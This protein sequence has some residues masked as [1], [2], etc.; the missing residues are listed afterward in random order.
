MNPGLYDVTTRLVFGINRLKTFKNI[1][2]KKL[3]L[4]MLLATALGAK[5]QDPHFSQFFEAPLY[6]NPS[7]AGL[8]KG[9]V[10]A[11]GVYRSQ[12]SSVTTPY[13][14][15]S[16][17]F[18]YKHP[19]GESNDF[20]T[21]GV[22]ML[23]DRAGSTALTT[24]NFLPALNYHK[25]LSG[26]KSKYLSLGFMA[27]YVGRSIDRSKMIT[28]NSYTTGYAG[29]TF[30]NAN[31]HYLDGSV[32]MS[33]NS[34][35]GDNSDNSYF[36]GLALHHL[37]QAKN[38][39]YTNAGF[40]VQPKW[41]ASAGV[42]LAANDYSY[43]TIQADFSKQGNYTEI[44]G[45]LLYSYKLGPDPDAPDYVLHFGGFV[46]VKDSFIPVVKVDYN[47]FS[48]AISYDVTTSQLI[49]A[50]Q[51]RGGAELSVTYAAFSN[52]N[53]S[54]RNAVLCPRF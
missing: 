27:G 5:A 51:A 14:N 29:E 49:T 54:T 10:R 21:M 2:M 24:T 11:Q 48:V 38:T 26:D 36:V 22:Q 44:I 40:E 34:Y 30:P 45:G 41:V 50:S 15:G 9:D 53:N 47:L 13:V 31:Y 19:V 18:E 8:F 39:F 17:N 52:R 12:W 23:Y 37:N 20:V 6:R 35:I 46:R 3:Y 4:I 7:L 32:G 25:A 1:S 43:F 28:D 16:F 33:F 42:K